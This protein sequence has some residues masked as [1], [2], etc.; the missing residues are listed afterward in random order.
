MLTR[1]NHWAKVIANIAHRRSKSRCAGVRSRS[2]VSVR[3]GAQWTTGVPKRRGVEGLA[4]TLRRSMLT[5][6]AR[7]NHSCCIRQYRLEFRTCGV[8]FG[9]R[10]QRRPVSAAANDVCSDI[11]VC[12]SCDRLW[13]ESAINH[14][15]R[16]AQIARGNLDPTMSASNNSRSPKTKLL[17]VW[18]QTIASFQPS[19]MGIRCENAGRHSWFRH[20]Q[21]GHGAHSGGPVAAHGG[22]WD[23]NRVRRCSPCDDFDDRKFWKKTADSHAPSAATWKS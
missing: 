20:R 5:C 14:A 1:E 6:A 16:R 13:A 8:V 21:C 10:E 9:F 12:G 22:A 2:F 15:P 19:V 11:S 23:R 3:G 18:P 7:V 4:W 17:D